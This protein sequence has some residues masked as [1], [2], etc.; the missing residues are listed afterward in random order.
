MQ[1]DGHQNVDKYYLRMA[2]S[3]NSDNLTFFLSF[4]YITMSMCKKQNEDGAR[5]VE[6]THRSIYLCTPT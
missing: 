4:T 2:I 5:G 3:S 6:K 1:K